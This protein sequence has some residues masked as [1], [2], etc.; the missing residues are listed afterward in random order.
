MNRFLLRFTL[1]LLLFSSIFLWYVFTPEQ[2]QPAQLFFP[3]ILAL[4]L[5]SLF[6]NI[7]WNAVIGT[8][9]VSLLLLAVY[10]ITTPAAHDASQL[11]QIMIAI[12]IVLFSTYLGQSI[13]TLKDQ[14]QN[15]SNP[16]GNDSILYLNQVRPLIESEFA[17]GYRYNYPIVMVRIKGLPKEENSKSKNLLEE[18]LQKLDQQMASFL[19]QNLRVT[20]ILVHLAAVNDF[21]LICPSINQE[22]ATHMIKRLTELVSREKFAGFTHTIASFPHDGRSFEALLNKLG[23]M[24]V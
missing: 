18:N 23:I 11:I 7:R 6:V 20:D 5:I 4:S 22:N 12:I 21:L 19:T 3:T 24:D 14:L 9:G 13:R 17:R 15:Q 10:F 2:W 16:A 1:F 8:I